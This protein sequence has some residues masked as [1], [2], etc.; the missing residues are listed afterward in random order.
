MRTKLLLLMAFALMG[1]SNVWAETIWP[2][3]G[4]GYTIL[5]DEENNRTARLDEYWW[6]A[7]G[8][9]YANM[10]SSFVYNEKTYTVTEVGDGTTAV[11]K[12]NASYT[13]VWFPDNVKAVNAYAFSYYQT[14]ITEI[15]MDGVE[16][17]KGNA[18]QNMDALTK[19]T[20]PASITTIEDYAFNTCKALKE[21]RFKGSMAPTAYYN[22][23]YCY[24]GDESKSDYLF[25]K[26]VIYIPAGSTSSYKPGTYTVFDYFYYVMEPGTFTIGETGYA[27]YFHSWCGFKVPEGVTAKIVTGI[28][29]GKLTIV[30]KYAAESIVPKNCGVLLNGSAD[31]YTFDLLPLDATEYPSEGNYLAGTDEESTPT[32]DD[33]Y[34]YYK[35]ANDATHGLGWYWGADEGA[36]FTNGAHKA[37]LKVSKG[38]GARSFIGLGDETTAIESVV[39]KAEINDGVYYNLQGQRVDNPTKG[40]YIVNGKKVIIK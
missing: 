12:K 6:E 15:V 21:M 20:F 30:D 17:I 13:G 16:T 29:G 9:G 27:T 4:N 40:L 8:T 35:L 37:C 33:N 32:N 36:A 22:S 38:A 19:V 34:Y 39:K 14:G 18:F 10:P 28:S 11:L 2:G 25:D 26:C 31:T 5:T 7:S 23:F 3:D 1:W 24:V